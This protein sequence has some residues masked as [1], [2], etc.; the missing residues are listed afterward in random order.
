MSTVST[1]RYA[2]V[3]ASS[4][5]QYVTNDSTADSVQQGDPESYRATFEIGREKPKDDGLNQVE[6]DAALLAW[7]RK[8][9]ARR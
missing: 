8:V 7:S 4:T 3:S 1:S 6:P 5:R 9:E 2:A